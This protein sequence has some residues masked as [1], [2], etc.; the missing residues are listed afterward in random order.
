VD[1]AVKYGTRGASKEVRVSVARA[2]DGVALRVADAG[3]GIPPEVRRRL[4]EPFARGGREETRT[5]RG[6]GLGLA[7]V[8]RYAEAMGASVDVESGPAGTIVSVRFH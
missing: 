6:V 1:N 4:F 2:P 8:R 7:L 3:P 5:A